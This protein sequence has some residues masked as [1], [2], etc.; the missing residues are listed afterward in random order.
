M[1]QVL[2]K[3]ILALVVVASMH[4][5]SSANGEDGKLPPQ[6]FAIRKAH[7]PQLI[8]RGEAEAYVNQV[9]AIDKRAVAQG[10]F[11]QKYA[12]DKRLYVMRYPG[13]RYRDIVPAFEGVYIVTGVCDVG[14]TPYLS[15]TRLPADGVEVPKKAVVTKDTYTFVCGVGAG[16][17][18]HGSE[19]TVEYVKRVG[20]DAERVK[21]L[22]VNQMSESGESVIPP[23]MP[24]TQVVGVGDEVRIGDTPHKIVNIV[25]PDEET[26]V[27]G[28]CELSRDSK[29]AIPAEKAATSQESKESIT[30][31]SGSR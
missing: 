16:G 23:T 28:W 5:L 24:K 14:Q 26:H 17:T 25:A 31:Q 15:F 1:C 30:S 22:R 19:F 8:A 6:Q 7:V 27:L 4:G 9:V 18:L 11:L 12:N 29:D 3:S 2:V 20:A 10:A 13:L 21:I